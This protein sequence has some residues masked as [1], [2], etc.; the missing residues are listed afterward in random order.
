MIKIERIGVAIGLIIVLSGIAGCLEEDS[1]V[2]YETPFNVW[3]EGISTNEAEQRFEMKLQLTDVD[4]FVTE[5]DGK[6]R[7]IFFDEG[8]NQVMD[9]TYKVKAK[10]FTTEQVNFVFDTWYDV[11]VP[12]SDIPNITPAMKDNPESNVTADVW[13][14]F[15]TPS[16]RA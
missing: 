6:F 16:S 11:N 4:D 2:D 13:F 1:S 15:G 8:L 7:V 5:Y 10:D 14:T 9:K 3:M 12:W